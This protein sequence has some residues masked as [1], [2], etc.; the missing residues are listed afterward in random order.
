MSRSDAYLSGRA[1]DSNALGVPSDSDPD[2]WS[3]SSLTDGS[4]GAP[5]WSSHLNSKASHILRRASFLG[6]LRFF[7]VPYRARRLFSCSPGGFCCCHPAMTAC[8][9][10][11]IRAMAAASCSSASE[12][13]ESLDTLRSR[14]EDPVALTAGILCTQLR[15][16]SRHELSSSM[17]CAYGQLNPISHVS[18]ATWT[19]SSRFRSTPFLN[20]TAQGWIL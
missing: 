2:V 17:E 1:L 11:L 18:S 16:S 12:A 13:L 9:L 10:A 5:C 20:R 14:P 15:C 19:A 7:A 3:F 8:R 6:P 4:P